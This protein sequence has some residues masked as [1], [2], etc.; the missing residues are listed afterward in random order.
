MKSAI[1]A[2]N[3]S[4]RLILTVFELFISIAFL[5]KLFGSDS[6]SEGGLIDYVR[7]FIDTISDSSAIAVEGAG[8]AGPITFLLLVLGAMLLSLVLFNLAPY[9]LNKQEEDD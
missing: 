4:L 9:M 2:V 6:Y 1:K 8:L 5:L 3:S 7:Q